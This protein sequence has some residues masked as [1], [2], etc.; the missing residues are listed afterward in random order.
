[1]GYLNLRASGLLSIVAGVL[2]AS[3]MFFHPA[4]N[5]QGALEPIWV[6]VHLAWFLS[7]ILIICSFIPIYVPLASSKNF[8]LTISYWLAFVGSLL[9]LPIAVWDSFVIPYLARHAPD[10]IAQIEETSTETSVLVFRV[11][12]FLTIFI[13]SLG[14]ILYGIALVQKRFVPILSG[15]CLAVGAPLFWVGA[16]FVS[17]GSMGNLITDIGAFLFGVGFVFFGVTLF[18]NPFRFDSLEMPSNQP[19][20]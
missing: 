4:N 3:F 20:A 8:L 11:I 15:F 7:Y 19:A 14:F 13:F 12:V 2:F 1:M 10:F 16:L 5:A 6:P 18:S 17:K 9:C